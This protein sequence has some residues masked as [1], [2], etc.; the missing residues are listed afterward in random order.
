MKP[1][2]IPIKVAVCVLCGEILSFSIYG[3]VC[4][5]KNCPDYLLEKHDDL[6]ENEYFPD[7][8]QNQNITASGI[9]G[10]SVSLYH[11]NGGSI[12]GDH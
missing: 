10:S 11:Y 12:V 2:N 1:K 5:K 4:G 8:F 7:Q 3:L 6:S 9:S